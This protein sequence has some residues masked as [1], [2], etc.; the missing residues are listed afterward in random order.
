MISESI[1]KNVSAVLNGYLARLNEISHNARMY[2]LFVLLTTLNVGV[3]GVIFN[4]YILRLGFKEDFLGLILSLSSTS[5]GVFAIPAALVCDRLGRKRT[6]LYSTLLL[7]LSLFF[8]TIPALGISWL[9]S[10]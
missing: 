3:Y 6:L 1:D 4:L 2:L 10:A 9:F 8:C 5:I 7:A